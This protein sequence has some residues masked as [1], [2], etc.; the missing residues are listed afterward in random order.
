M[1]RPAPPGGAE[2]APPAG[3]S[4]SAGTA[5]VR[6]PRR[7]WFGLERNVHMGFKPRTTSL[8]WALLS[9]WAQLLAGALG[10]PTPGHSRIRKK[11]PLDVTF[12]HALNGP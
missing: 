5:A 9:S 7:R 11:P 10:V 12:V 4:R 6:S 2:R 3:A 8:S 1:R